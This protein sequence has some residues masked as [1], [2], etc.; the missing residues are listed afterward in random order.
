MKKNNHQI[1]EQQQ[2]EETLEDY[3]KSNPYP[4]ENKSILSQITSDHIDRVIELASKPET[5]FTKNCIYPLPKGEDGETSFRKM[6]NAFKNKDTTKKKKHPMLAFF[7]MNPVKTTIYIIIEVAKSLLDYSTV[8]ISK[9]AVEEVSRQIESEGRVVN[10]IPVFIA[11]LSV[12]FIKFFIRTFNKLF[13]KSKDNLK[14]G[15]ITGL[16]ILAFE[17]MMNIKVQNSKDH[18]KSKIKNYIHS[19]IGRLHGAFWFA[20]SILEESI[21]LVI[22]VYMGLTNFGYSFFILI[23][24]YGLI[25]YYNKKT[26]K[27]L[28]KDDKEIRELGDKNRRLI[29]NTIEHM[30]FVKIRSLENIMYSKIGKSKFEQIDKQQTKNLKFDTFIAAIDSAKGIIITAF[31]CLSFYSGH[32][33]T[34]GRL[35]ILMDMFDRLNHYM[36]MIPYY[37]RE[38]KEKKESNTKVSGFYEAEELDLSEVMEKEQV[39]RKF[40]VEIKN[41]GFFWGDGKEEEDEEERKNE[42]KENEEEKKDEEEIK[43]EEKENEEEKK[44]EDEKK[45]KKEKKKSKQYIFNIF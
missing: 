30:K 35:L 16:K 25:G 41:G 22:M 14:G 20:S 5:K 2:N 37:F 4:L 26:F 45:E 23:I 28:E 17:K 7:Y 9:S 40:A 33:L 10:K 12:W 18:D 29:K 36:W 34:I 24:G 6:Q 42:E 1:K 32:S 44:D 31:L 8:F 19:D 11:F 21:K 13:D 39:D 27:K 3:I 43:N 15:S 38:F